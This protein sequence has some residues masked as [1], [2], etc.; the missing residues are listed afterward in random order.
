[1]FRPRIF[2]GVVLFFPSMASAQPNGPV[3]T[4]TVRK[5]IDFHQLLEKVK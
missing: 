1:M 3:A 4:D 2:L 5:D